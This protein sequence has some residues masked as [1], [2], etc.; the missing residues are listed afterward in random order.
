[1]IS[2]SG[3]TQNIRIRSCGFQCDVPFIMDHNCRSALS[4]YT[5]KT[6]MACY[7]SV[8]WH[9]SVA[10]LN[11]MY[12]CYSYEPMNQDVK[13]DVTPIPPPNKKD[14]TKLLLCLGDSI[15]VIIML[16]PNKTNG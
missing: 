6:G 16:L 4:L 12:H 1:M 9:F 5:V 3:Q 8:A 13:S 2:R 15:K 10:A 7:V 11:S 14:K